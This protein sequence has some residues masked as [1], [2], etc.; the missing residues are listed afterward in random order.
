MARKRVSHPEE[1]DLIQR[2]RRGDQEARTIVVRKHHSAL[3]HQ[4]FLVL[5]D[6]ALAEEVVQDAWLAAFLC[7]GKFDGRSSVFTWL[8]RIVINKAKSRRRRETRSLPFSALARRSA[9]R[10]GVGGDEEAEPIEAGSNE[11]TPEW[12]AM[13]QEALRRFDDALRALPEGQRSVVVLRDLDGASSAETCRV[14]RINDLTQRVRLSRG[15]A[16]LR[17]AIQERPRLAAA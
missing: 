17:S 3:L 2:L 5:R 6:E 8:V 13:E 7:I 12:I 11:I 1:A 16:A 9:S 14:L 10:D 15:R 4:A